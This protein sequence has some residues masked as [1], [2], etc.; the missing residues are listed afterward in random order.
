MAMQDVIIGYAKGAKGEQGPRGEKGETGAQGPK[1][2]P[3]IQGPQGPRG[4]TGARGPT[5]P[6]GPQGPLPPLANNFL[7]TQA[8]VSA[9][10]AAAGKILKDQL[11]KQNSDLGIIYK[12]SSRRATIAHERA[13]DIT[14]YSE[15]VPKGTYIVIM[16][17]S[18]DINQDLYNSKG[19]RV[20]VGVGKVVVSVE[21]LSTDT[22]HVVGANF[23][24]TEISTSDDSA[25]FGLIL[26]RLK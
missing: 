26:V 19:E 7:T 6:A 23:T 16:R 1:G 18:H 24:G 17:C 11:D 14:E 9:L 5:G 21:E 2:D 15:I 22:Y 12:A 10:D 3:G 4:E 20:A 8:G 25:Y 13:S